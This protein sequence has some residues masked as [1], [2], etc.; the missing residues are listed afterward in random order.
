MPSPLGLRD[1]RPNRLDRAH[2]LKAERVAVERPPHEDVG[3]NL[4]CQ[5]RREAIDPKLPV[6]ARHEALRNEMNN[7]APMPVARRQPVPVARCQ[8]RAGGANARAATRIY[9]TAYP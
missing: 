3:A 6:A 8:L 7:H 9:P 4:T 5:F 1:V 2:E